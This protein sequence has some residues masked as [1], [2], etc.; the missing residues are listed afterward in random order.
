MVLDPYGYYT[1]IWG[2]VDTVG[3]SGNGIVEAEEAYEVA[4]EMKEQLESYGLTVV[5]ISRGE[6]EVV[7]YYGENCRASKGYQANANYLIAIGFS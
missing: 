7:E 1:T 4:L 5:L 2:G 3:S 6:E